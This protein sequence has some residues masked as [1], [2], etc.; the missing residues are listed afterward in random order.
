M[1]RHF[2]K[3]NFRRCFKSTAKVVF[4]VKPGDIFKDFS[5]ICNMF[6]S[7]IFQ[8]IFLLTLV[9]V[10][11]AYLSPKS[12]DLERRLISEGFVNI[13]DCDSTIKVNLMYASADNFTGIVLYDGF[14]KAYLHPSA[15][16]ALVKAQAAL[17][18]LSPEYS[19]LVK[20]AARPMSVQRRMFRAV[21]GTSKANYVANPAKGGGLH[22]YGLAVDIT[23]IDSQ[24][25]EL[26]MGTPVDHLGPEAN[27]DREELL[28]AKGT[29]S[30]TER[31]N[32]LLLRRVMTEAGFSPLR[33]EW[34]HFNF[35]SK[36]QARASYK[37][38]DF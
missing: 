9:M 2:K 1:M 16:K 29:I 6:S 11:P 15:A 38:L 3:N 33:T 28:V 31:Q 13:T 35:V 12:P 7:R 25:I 32:R 34:W 27:I 10:S 20:D 19:L 30:E 22:N 36:R 5:Y 8:Q 26:P 4:Y 24:G 21:A 37:R 23:I 14:D 17:R 18:R